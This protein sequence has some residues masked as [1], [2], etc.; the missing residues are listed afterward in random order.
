MSQRFLSRT[1][2]SLVTGS[3]VAAS[4]A[5]RYVREEY[6]GDDDDGDPEWREDERVTPPLLIEVAQKVVEIG[7]DTYRIDTASQRW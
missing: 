3:I 4:H 2:L 7:N 6:R 5:N 1:S